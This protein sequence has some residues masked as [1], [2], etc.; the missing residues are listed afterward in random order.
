LTS[1]SPLRYGFVKYESET[2]EDPVMSEHAIAE[3][4]ALVM[5]DE[6]FLARFE[7]GE[8]AGDAFPHRAHLRMAWLYVTR[9][10]PD[11]A[12]RKA[13]DGIRNLAQHH[14]RPALYHDTLTRAWVYLMAAGVAHSRSATFAD[15]L[16][17]NPQF[18]DK[19]LL[20]KHYSPEVL[21]SAR[22][23]AVWVA[24]DLI[25]IPGAPPSADAVPDPAPPSP[26]SAA[27]Y[28]D[29]LRSLPT[30]VAVVSAADGVDVH[31]LTASS[32]T[33]LSIDP[34]LVLVCLRRGSRILPM[35]RAS[36]HFGVSY[37]SEPQHELASHFASVTRPPG[38]AQ[39]HGIPHHAGRFGVPLL[40]EASALLECELW[41]EY[42]GGDHTII[43]GRVSSASSRSVHPLLT[44]AGQFRTAVQS[45]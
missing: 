2:N 8:F 44:Y 35:L 32:V 28:L 26:V 29:A 45:S 18:L 5:P 42:P 11:A 20:L 14:G 13:A 16:V 9:F 1:V 43:C 17:V 34:P 21:A 37:L 12:V 4:P 25:P 23:R 39:F 31:A 3:I 33:S 24:P 7:R 6:E 38:A 30:A 40:D 41:C 27:Q 19:R 36:R 15:F 10:G 22:A